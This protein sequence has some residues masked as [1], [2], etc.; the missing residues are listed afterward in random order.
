[1]NKKNVEQLNEVEL[2]LCSGGLDGLDGFNLS[3]A[4]R[5]LNSAK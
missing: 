5:L 2:E 1:M 3:D 4:N